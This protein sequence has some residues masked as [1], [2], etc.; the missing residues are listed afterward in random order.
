M[1]ITVRSKCNWLLYTC[2]NVCV[3]VSQMIGVLKQLK[4]LDV[5][6]NNLETVDEQ[7]S[8]CEN[9][10]D[11]LLSNNALTQLPSSIGKIITLIASR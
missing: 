9:L 1:P 2:D 8:S 5:S 11:L 3:C 4:Y 6:K 10:Q 7:I